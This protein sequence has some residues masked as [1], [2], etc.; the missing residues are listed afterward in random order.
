LDG[1]LA[2]RLE[3]VDTLLFDLDGTLLG[4]DMQVFLP[5]YLKAV[6]A[7]ASHL[8]DPRVFVKELMRATQAMIDNLD[9]RVS[10]AD[11]FAAV[12]YPS[13][14]LKREE[15]EPVFAE[16]YA[17]WFP[18]LRV[19]THVK[20]DARRCLL[21]AARRDYRLVLATNPVFP[22]AAIRERMRWADVAEIPWN[23]V[24][25]YEA[26]HFCKPHLAYYREILDLL[27]LSPEQCMM[28]G[29]D[30]EEDIVAGSLGMVTFL[31]PTQI[32]QRNAGPRRADFEGDLG[33]LCAILA[34]A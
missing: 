18:H 28:V 20:P 29:N 16:F 11:A 15:C 8:V 12:F 34:G 30:V 13:V 32:I 9:P 27:G 3:R 33:L 1:D 31:D 26:M 2:C 4:N 10:N 6:A 21:L 23:L 25:A 14:G 24:T 5:H 22:M 19:H 17:R 7:W